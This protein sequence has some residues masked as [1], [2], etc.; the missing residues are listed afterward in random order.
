M[1]RKPAGMYRTFTRVPEKY[2]GKRDKCSGM[3]GKLLKSEQNP[4]ESQGNTLKC[5]GNSLEYQG[6]LLEC[7][8]NPL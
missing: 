1:Q 8:V 7:L 2:A 3:P 6:N 5:Q 4:L